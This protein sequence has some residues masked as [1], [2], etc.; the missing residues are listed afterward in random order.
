MGVGVVGALG[1]DF[2]RQRSL[3][4]CPGVCVGPSPPA[5]IGCARPSASGWGASCAGHHVLLHPWIHLLGTLSSSAG[6][7]LPLTPS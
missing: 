5:L 1:L 4:S 7:P 2:K 6:L 3:L